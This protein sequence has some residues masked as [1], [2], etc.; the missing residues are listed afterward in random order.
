[1]D[2]KAGLEGGRGDEKNAYLVQSKY[3]WSLVLTFYF[4]KI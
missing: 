4:K 1:M 3:E 2:P